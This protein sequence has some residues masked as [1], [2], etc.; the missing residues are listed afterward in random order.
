MPEALSAVIVW[1]TFA[2]VLLSLDW[3][4]PK[5]CFKKGYVFGFVFNTGIM[6]WV[7]FAMKKYGGMSV[8][9]SVSIMFLL[10]AFLALYPAISFFLTARYARTPLQRVIL[11]SLFYSVLEWSRAFF[12]FGGVPWTNP[13]YALYGANTFIQALDIVGI[14][15][16]NFLILFGNW[17]LAEGLSYRANL[18][19]LRSCLLV[20]VIAVITC[21]IYGVF[22][23]KSIDA[24]MSQ[25]TPLSVALIQG[26]FTQDQKWVAST[27]E[28]IIQ[29]YSGLSKAAIE[30]AKLDLIVWPEAALPYSIQKD[31]PKMPMPLDFLGDTKLIFGASTY[32]ILGNQYFYLNS[33]FLA[34]SDGTLVKRYDKQHLVPFGEYV[35]LEKWIGWFVPSAA[36]NFF[37]GKTPTVFPVGKYRAA[38]IICYES[39]FPE[40]SRRMVE[41]GADFF[42][43]ITN[44]AWFDYTSGPFQHAQF[45]RFRAIEARRSLLRAANTGVSYWMDPT[46]EVHDATDLFETK[47]VHAKA[48]PLSIKTI[49][50]RFPW[51]IPSL[52][53]AA[54]GFFFLY[55]RRKNRD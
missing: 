29:T 32:E 14:H 30:T 40:I 4:Q 55:F 26:N 20:A 7:T 43:N 38:T 3:T 12:P 42:V 53:L 24:A 1:F 23:L 51:L 6:F 37:A 17:I 45:G 34:S 35:P 25:Q 50:V 28:K 19:P 15:G 27:R 54:L 13:G 36:G 5:D 46:G 10:V 33:S 2:P 49:Y 41:E 22:R 11:G 39:M 48:Y 31:T 47:T 52:L 8:L 21:F 9:L 16:F 44:D 18:R